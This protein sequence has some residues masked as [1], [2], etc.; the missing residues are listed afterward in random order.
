VAGGIER[1]EVSAQAGADE[2]HGLAGDRAVDDGE[3][4]GDGDVLEVARR[5]GRE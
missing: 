5:R 2:G 4:A 3:L 1:G